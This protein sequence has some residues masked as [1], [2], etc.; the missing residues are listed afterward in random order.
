[1]KTFHGLNSAVG[2]FTKAKV[3]LGT[4]DG[5][6]RGHLSVL[7]RLLAW[8]RETKGEAVVLTFDRPPRAALA[9]V[10]AKPMA[11]KPRSQRS[12][13]GGQILSLKHRLMLFD[14]LGLDATVVLTFDAALAALEPE[15]FV[16]NLLVDRLKAEGVLLGHDTRFGRGGRGD[17]DLMSRLGEQM[18]FETRSVPVVELDGAPVSS[19]R[20]REAIRAGDLRLAERLLGRRL[21]V[22][23]T[24]VPGLGRGRRIGFPTINLDLHHEVRPPQGVYATRCLIAGLPAGGAGL[25]AEGAGSLR[26]SVT[27]I[28]PAPTLQ[29]TGPAHLSERVIVETH[30]LDFSGDLYGQDIEVQFVDR[31][32]AEEVFQS[33]AALAERIA[34]DIREARRRLANA[35]PVEEEPFP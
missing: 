30:I 17:F 26:D 34:S 4:F 21:S 9:G 15:E 29:P 16:K 2:P 32:R 28:G 27:N 13:S 18:H 7:R 3:T 14:R 23:G 22:Y 35:P 31:I 20:L 6:H 8:A 25:P 11:G 1:M 12:V 19:T 10:P 5:V 33:A 24:V